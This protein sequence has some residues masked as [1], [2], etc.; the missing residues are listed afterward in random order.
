MAN[1]RAIAAKHVRVA[2]ADP[3]PNAAFSSLFSAHAMLILAVLMRGATNVSIVAFDRL[4]SEFS[5]SQRTV[6]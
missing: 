3:I 2:V 6:S 1:A 5:T 4:I